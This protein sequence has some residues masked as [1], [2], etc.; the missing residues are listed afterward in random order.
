MR[1]GVGLSCIVMGMGG[2]RGGEVIVRDSGHGEV[3]EEATMA[4]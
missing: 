2:K 3:G 4:V 1:V